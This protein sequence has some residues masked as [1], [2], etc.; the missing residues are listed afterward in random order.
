MSV[1]KKKEMVITNHIYQPKHEIIGRKEAQDRIK[2]VQ[3]ETKSIAIHT[4]G[5][6]GIRRSGGKTRRYNKDHK[7]VSNR[8]SKRILSICCRECS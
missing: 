2:E 5:G 1:E 3:Y 6:Q 7:K 4:D 8:G